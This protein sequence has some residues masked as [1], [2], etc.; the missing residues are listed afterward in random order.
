MTLSRKSLSRLILL[1]SGATI[2]AALGFQYIGGLEPCALCLQQRY[3]YYLVVPL[4]LFCYLISEDEDK[5]AIFRYG[6][7]IC[8]LAML[9]NTALGSYH[10]GAEWGFWP[11]PA[12]CS[13]GSVDGLTPSLSGPPPVDCTKAAWRLFGISMA[14]YN[15][16]ISL[17]LFTLTSLAS[18]N[19][20]KC[21][22]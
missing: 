4:S 13:T 19:P 11:G 3:A 15:A 17:G 5:K 1:I 16:L 7:L 14:G 8:G 9:A 22:I 12:T 18:C 20:T 6:I 2:L 21:K 10:A